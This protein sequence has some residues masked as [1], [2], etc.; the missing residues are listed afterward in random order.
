VGWESFAQDNC[1]EG[2]RV[3]IGDEKSAQAKAQ[4]KKILQS[5]PCP[6]R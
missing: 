1:T 6:H 5:H 2:L 4:A 3:E